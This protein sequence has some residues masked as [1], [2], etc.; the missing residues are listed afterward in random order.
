MTLA[1]D[2]GAHQTTADDTGADQTTADDTAAVETTDRTATD[3]VA[4]HPGENPTP[5]ARVQQVESSDIPRPPAP[6]PAAER[7]RRDAQR[8]RSS[9]QAP[10]E[11]DPRDDSEPEDPATPRI[12]P[13]AEAMRLL[14]S[15]FGARPIE[16]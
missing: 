14:E 12:D 7:Q 3:R 15:A 6:R 8:A 10:T 4:P 13:E 9:A 2:T 11:L 5:P 16:D 1:D